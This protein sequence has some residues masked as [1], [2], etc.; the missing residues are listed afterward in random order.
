LTRALTGLIS[1]TWLHGAH[2]NRRVDCSSPPALR[3]MVLE[4]QLSPADF[5]YPLGLLRKGTKQRSDGRDAPGA[6]RGALMGLAMEGGGAGV[7]SRHPLRGA[8]SE[9]GR[10]SSKSEDGAECFNEGRPVPLAIRRGFKAGAPG[11]GGR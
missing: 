2:F 9:G 4:F 10:C 5:I 6:C 3:A 1:S 8:A 7:G 11:D